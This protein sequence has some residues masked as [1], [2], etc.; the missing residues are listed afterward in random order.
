MIKYLKDMAN[1]DYGVVKYGVLDIHDD[2]FEFVSDRK[3]NLG[4]IAKFLDCGS[5]EIVQIDMEIMNRRNR[6][7]KCTQ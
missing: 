7:W 4:E 2:Y 5:E 1:N 6:K 3:L